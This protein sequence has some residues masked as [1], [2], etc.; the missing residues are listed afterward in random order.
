MSKALDT[1]AHQT[2]RVLQRINMGNRA[3][4]EFVCL[5]DGGSV[6]F[7]SQ[8]LLR[9]VSIVDPNFDE[10]WTMRSEIA[11]RLSGLF[12]RRNDIRNVIASGIVRTR[13]RP[14]QPPPYSTE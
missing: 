14:R 11:Y 2:F 7:R 1:G 4:V 8:F 6:Q 9:A 3:Q 10:V 12:D 13:S 5:I